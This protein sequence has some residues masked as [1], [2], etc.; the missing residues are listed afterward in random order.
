MIIVKVDFKKPIKLSQE[1][2]TR[3]LNELVES[4]ARLKRVQRAA[5]VLGFDINYPRNFNTVR[6]ILVGGNF[7]WVRKEF[8]HPTKD[9]KDCGCDFIITD[10]E[11]RY[12]KFRKYGCPAHLVR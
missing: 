7:N 11:K 2:L 9:N 12:E 4:A 3:K 6:P 8:P 10:S 5:I 1:E